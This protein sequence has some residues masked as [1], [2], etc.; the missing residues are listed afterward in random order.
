MKTIEQKLDDALKELKD[1]K[2]KSIS[3]TSITI[4]VALIGSLT[5]FIGIG[6]N[7]YIVG[8]ALMTK[9]RAEERIELRKEGLSQLLK[10]KSSFEK[11]CSTEMNDL[12]KKELEMSLEEFQ[13]FSDKIGAYYPSPPVLTSLTNYNDYVAIKYHEINSS[14]VDNESAK[15]FFMQS[16]GLYE[17]ARE[18]IDSITKV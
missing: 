4:I 9:A 13:K 11:L 2:E 12:N 10:V 17:S 5:T 16:N 18:A 7:Y 3:K 15:V 1:L 6:I 8:P 14:E